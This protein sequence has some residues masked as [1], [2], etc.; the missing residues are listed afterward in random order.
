MASFAFDTITPAQALTYSAALDQLEFGPGDGSASGATVA[1]LAASG[2]TPDEVAVTAAGRTVIFGAGLYGEAA[3]FADGSL[4]F[5]GGP[6][7]ESIPG[8]DA[9]DGLFGS[10]GADNFSGGGGADL[11]QGNQ[12]PDTLSGGDGADVL[13][14]GRGADALDLGAG[15][16]FAQGNLGNDTLAATGST[17]PNILLGGQ[18]DD[19]IVGGAGG[20]FLNGNLGADSLA[21]GDGADTLR[22]EGGVDT[23]S[24]GPGADLFVFS[25][26]DADT[27]PIGADRVT[28]WTIEDHIH[29]PDVLG[30][31]F[32]QALPPTVE[33]PVYDPY[34]YSGGTMSRPLTWDD[35]VAQA[36]NAMAANPAVH[37]VSAQVGNDVA[38]LIDTDGNLVSDLAIVLVGATQAAVDAASFV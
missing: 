12:G 26:G 9:A 21:G 7:G 14:G 6:L 18:G 31:S 13:Y 36:N 22:G 34:G 5:V 38:L 28:D 19:H 33:T 11:L 35:A 15:A 20:D 30:P 25:N 32:F 8:T 10:H 29:V 27:S 37:V 3:H 24:G 23:L 4:L 1:Y 2:A 16:G 17:G